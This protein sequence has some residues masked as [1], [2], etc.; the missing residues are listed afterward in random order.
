MLSVCSVKVIFFIPTNLK[1]PF[2]IKSKDDLFPKNT[3]RDDVSSITEKDDIHPRKDDIDI[4][5]WHSRKCSND[6]LYFYGD[7]FKC[8]HILLS[9]KKKTGNLIY[10]VEIWHYLKVVLLEIFYNEEPSIICTIQSSGVVSR[11]VPE[12]QLRKILVH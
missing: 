8:F 7:L 12:R 10:R 1:L 5:D 6:S 2:C 9:N 4:L 3:P 11:D